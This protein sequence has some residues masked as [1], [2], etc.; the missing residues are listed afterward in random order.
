MANKHEQPPQVQAPRSTVSLINDPAYRAVWVEMNHE[1]QKH[2]TD[3]APATNTKERRGRP[4][5]TPEM[6]EGMAEA[7]GILQRRVRDEYE[8]LKDDRLLFQ[9]TTSDRPDVFSLGGDLEKFVQ[10]VEL[11][12]VDSL[13]RYAQQCVELINAA[14]THYG[15]PF[16]TIALVQGDAFGG[17]F[18]CALANNVIVAERQAVFRFPER[19]IGMF[20]GMGAVS[21]LSRKIGVAAARRMIESGRLYYA[22]ELYDMGVV[23]ILAPIGEGKEAV[24]AYM[25]NDIGQ[26]ALNQAFDRVQEIPEA[27]LQ[28]IVNLWVDTVMRL[29]AENLKL[30]KRIVSVQGDV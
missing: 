12:D 9:V 25:R 16:T 23:D 26:S 19:Q 20:P 18:E 22:Q 15:V 28:S 11:G 27:E 3:S 5:F 2:T 24:E 30:I 29:S 1:G 21:I 10:W 8:A 17:G 4:C 7:K 14:W 6:L 13:Y